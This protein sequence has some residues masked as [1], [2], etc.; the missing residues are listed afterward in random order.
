MIEYAHEGACLDQPRRQVMAGALAVWQ[1]SQPLTPAQ[2]AALG[3][4]FNE[5]ERRGETG[6]SV[7]EWTRPLMMV[8]SKK[9]DG[10]ERRGVVQARNAVAQLDAPLFTVD[11]AWLAQISRAEFLR[12]RDPGGESRALL[13]LPKTCGWPPATTPLELPRFVRLPFGLKS[14]GSAYVNLMHVAMNVFK[15]ADFKW[16]YLDDVIIR[17]GDAETHLQRLRIML[18]S[19]RRFVPERDSG[20]SST[21]RN[22]AK[23]RRCVVLIIGHALDPGDVHRVPEWPRPR[24]GRSLR[25]VL[26]LTGHHQ[27]AIGEH[28]QLPTEL[29]ESQAEAD[30]TI[31]SEK[32]KGNVNRL[33]IAANEPAGA[34]PALQ[35]PPTAGP[36]Q[37]PHRREDRV[38][39]RS[40]QDTPVGK[41]RLRLIRTL[42]HMCVRRTMC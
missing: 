41:N 25:A 8:C 21:H 10:P 26:E 40:P 4:P 24:T 13:A 42:K 2:A 27:N 20:E 30:D 12:P 19:L 14:T 15:V 37:E 39:T 16:P 17:G 1:E 6:E 36:G 38:V 29:A 22:S 7:R 34:E 5:R 11:R 9:T 3:Q 28:G 18:E 33:G 31:W 32:L 35:S 23:H